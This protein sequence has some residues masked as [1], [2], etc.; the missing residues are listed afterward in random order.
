MHVLGVSSVSVPLTV[1]P[2]GL[3]N[4]NLRASGELVELAVPIGGEST[5]S[6]AL[7][8]DPVFVGMP[9]FQQSL[10]LGFTSGGQ[11]ASISASNLLTLN[12]GFF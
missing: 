12:L 5:F 1:L 2:Q 7:P 6:F 9:L 3:P 4:C 8:S 10:Q 11:F